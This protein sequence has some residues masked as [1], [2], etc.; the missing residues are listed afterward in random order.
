[1]ELVNLSPSAALFAAG[2]VLLAGFMRGFTG[3]GGGLVMVP[4]L[5]LIMGPPA[6]VAIAMLMET[7]ATAR[8]IPGAVKMW[9]WRAMLPLSIGAVVLIPFGNYLLIHSD[10]NF[11]RRFIAILVI[12]YALVLLA[13]FRY[14]GPRRASI[15]GGVGLV[16]GF[17]NGLGGMGGPPIVLYLMSGSD[18]AAQNRANIQFYALSIQFAAIASLTLQG[19]IVAETLWRCALFAPFSF[20]GVWLGSRL[21]SRASDQI[22][23]RVALAFL[24]V[25]GVY[26]LIA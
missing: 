3:F 11:I 18:S 12:F 25:V 4:T 9:N 2:L 24:L 23:R 14:T 7:L 22:Y 15:S 8:M 26:V 16:A 19:V 20:L 6:A 21:F 13:G 1:M 10:P 5:T 17:I